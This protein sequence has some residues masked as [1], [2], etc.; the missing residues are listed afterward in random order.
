MTT[1]QTGKAGSE[2]F[3]KLAL[4]GV[5]EEGS[6]FFW[7]VAEKGLLGRLGVA[8]ADLGVRQ[9]SHLDA[10][11]IGEAERTP[12]PLGHLAMPQIHRI[13]AP[14]PAAVTSNTQRRAVCLPLDKA[15]RSRRAVSTTARSFHCI[16]TPSRCA[17]RRDSLCSRSGSSWKLTNPC[18]G[19]PDPRFGATHG[20]SR[21]QRAITQVF[22]HLLVSPDVRSTLEIAVSGQPLDINNITF[23]GSE[24]FGKAA[25]LTG[26]F[27]SQSQRM[28]YDGGLTNGVRGI[29]CG[30]G[31]NPS[32]AVTKAG[33]AN[34]C[35]RRSVPS[36][37]GFA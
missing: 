3:V 25:V 26:L 16:G 2:E 8:D 28:P 34:E 17:Q 13:S 23:S 19:Q 33:I 22:E 37:G 15:S 1:P 14:A 21:A 20:V 11:A 18:R 27:A 29:R 32:H 30:S 31:S 6:S 10:I 12:A 24:E 7:C 9:A 35:R 36:M 4:L 5:C